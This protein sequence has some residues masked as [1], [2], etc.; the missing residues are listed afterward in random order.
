MSELKEALLQASDTIGISLTE[1]QLL[2]FDCYYTMLIDWNNRMNLTAI[3]TPEEVAV[4]HFADSLLL[5]RTVNPL[6]GARIADVGTGAGFPAV[7]VGIVRDDLHLI[8]IDSLNKRIGFLKELCSALSLEA[9]CIH[10]RAEDLG[11]S[12]LREGQD[13]VTARA[14]A[15]LRTLSEYCLPFVKV[16]GEFVALKGPEI[17]E[18]L[19]E[20]E[21]AI[22]ILGGAL[23]KIYRFE[24]PDGS[25]RTILRIKKISQT[26]TKYPRTPAKISKSPLI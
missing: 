1:K 14:V 26:P 5:L 21:G 17:E 15:H 22:H 8:L 23:E 3:T 25:R 7:P 16:G 11:K 18:E 12:S 10:G 6:Q 2:K 20:A 4:K 24:L 9:D 19:K 13:L